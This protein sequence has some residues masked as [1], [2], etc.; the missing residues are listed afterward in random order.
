MSG[1]SLGRALMNEGCL[2]GSQQT[3]RPAPAGRPESVCLAGEQ[4]AGDGTDCNFC[5]L[6][7][8]IASEILVSAVGLPVGLSGSPPVCSIVTAS[9]MN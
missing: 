4:G 5:G 8:L 9:I 7:V 3:S 1:L 6:F 2:G